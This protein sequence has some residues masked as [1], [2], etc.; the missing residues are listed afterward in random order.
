MKIISNHFSRIHNL[1]FLRT[2]PVATQ[3]I[4]TTTA[5]SRSKSTQYQRGNKSKEIHIFPPPTRKAM[6]IQT[7]SGSTIQRTLG[8]DNSQPD[9]ESHP[10][11]ALKPEPTAPIV[12]N[13]DQGAVTLPASAFPTPKLT[14]KLSLPRNVRGSVY[15]NANYEEPLSRAAGLWSRGISFKSWCRTSS[16]HHHHHTRSFKQRLHRH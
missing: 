11:L 15:P 5:G 1:D 3:K 4:N 13:S 7:K 6:I 2:Q 8:L 10:Q 16:K 12:M 9:L 14:P